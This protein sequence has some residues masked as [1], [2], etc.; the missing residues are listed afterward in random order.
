MGPK[1]LKSYVSWVIDQKPELKDTPADVKAELQKQFEERLENLV[2]AAILAE[3]PESELEHFQRLLNHGTEEDIQ[4]FCDQ[5]VPNLDEVVARV[6][7]QFRNEY[8]EV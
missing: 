3:V 4:K 2:N 1:D 8:L 7:V 5:V 6:L